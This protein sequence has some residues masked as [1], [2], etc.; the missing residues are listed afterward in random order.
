LIDSVDLPNVAVR[1]VGNKTERR[2][3][4]LRRTTIDA[5]VTGAEVLV[6]A[7]ARDKQSTRRFL[8][9][10]CLASG[11]YLHS[12]L[13]PA[14]ARLLAANASHY[15]VLTSGDSASILARDAPHACSTRRLSNATSTLR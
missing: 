7:S 1:A 4:G 14:Q 5:V 8:D 2:L 6:L 15:F 12:E 13:A 10:Y 3:T 11:A 9:H